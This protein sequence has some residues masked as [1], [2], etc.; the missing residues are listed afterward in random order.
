MLLFYLYYIHKLS[1][2]SLKAVTKRHENYFFFFQ[3]LYIKISVLML[4]SL[5]VF[6]IIREIGY[7][8]I[9]AIN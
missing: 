2:I 8:C 5:F 7:G 3:D 6:I 9:D 4:N 1:C